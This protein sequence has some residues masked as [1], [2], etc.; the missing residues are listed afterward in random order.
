M[1]F[2][3]SRP[4]K[5]EMKIL[6][7]SKNPFL[8]REEFTLHLTSEKNPSFAEVKDALGKDANLTIVKSISGNF[9]RESFNAEVLVYDSDDSKNKIEK[10]S[11]KE[12]KKL[13]E[14]A[15][16]AAAPAQ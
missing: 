11:R 7:Q 5:M 1:D 8:H 12:R 14:E 13:A 16:K 10:I 15:K 9:G 4:N 6:K 3:L 2:M